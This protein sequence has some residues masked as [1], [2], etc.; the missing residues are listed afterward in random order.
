VKLC[1]LICNYN[2]WELLVRCARE[3]RRT[4][5]ALP[6]V[7]VD[8]SSSE[9]CSPADLPPDIRFVRRERRGGFASALNSGFAATD[10]DLIVVFDADAYPL[11]E[12]S[13]RVH[14]RF[15]ESSTLAMLGFRSFDEKGA[16][17]PSTAGPPE[18]L[19]FIWGQRLAAWSRRVIRGSTARPIR[20]PVLAGVAV[21]RSAFDAVGGF[22]ENLAFLD[23][24]VDFGWRLIG[25]GWRIEQDDELGIFH[26]GGGSSLHTGERVSCF[27]RDR[28]WTL[29]KHSML[30]FPRLT[31][32]F[33]QARLLLEARVLEGLAGLSMGRSSKYRGAAAGRRQAVRLLHAARDGGE[34]PDLP[35]RPV[36]LLDRSRRRRYGRR[37][38]ESSGSIDSR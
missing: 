10:A 29:R 8:D 14:R 22:D 26:V 3:V 1:A 38:R 12:F 34:K 6:I 5:S 17:T 37:S 36:A 9:P 23:V 20:I 18:S 28:W 2:S 11:G 16:E 25:S 4:E 33:V 21:R 19:E 24:D 31:R 32:T 7:V 30:R 13:Q 35:A 27:Y 15:E